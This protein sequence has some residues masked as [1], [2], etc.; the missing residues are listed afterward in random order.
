MSLIFIQL[1]WIDV[2]WG[3][4]EG[5]SYIGSYIRRE[6]DR[7]V[8]GDLNRTVRLKGINFS[9]LHW[10]SDPRKIVGG[11]HHRQRDF[12]RIR[13]MGFNVIRFNVHQ[14]LFV[15]NPQLGWRALKG[16]AWLDT[17]I[18]WARKAGIKLIIN[19]HVPLGGEKFWS[20]PDSWLD[21]L[22]ETWGELARRY[23]NEPVIAAWNLLNKPRGEVGKRW[24]FISWRLIE[25]IRKG[26]EHHLIIV[27]YPLG[28]FKPDFVVEGDD[29]LIYEFHF[30][31]PDQFTHQYVPQSGRGDGGGYDHT[32]YAYIPEERKWGG[33]IEGKP[34]KGGTTDWHW[35]E[36]QAFR[37]EDV[38]SI[39]AY[40]QLICRDE[41]GRIWLDDFRVDERFG[42]HGEW[43]TLLSVDIVSKDEL[44]QVSDKEPYPTNPYRQQVK[45][46]R[47]GSEGRSVVGEGE[48][49]HLG[50]AS[51]EVGSVQGKVALSNDRLM[52]S[53]RPGYEYRLGGW[54]RGQNVSGG[55][56]SLGV[57][58]VSLPKGMKRIPIDKGIL[59]KRLERFLRFGRDENVP[60][61][62]GEFGLSRMAFRKG[63]NG[64]RWVEDVIKLL[65]EKGLS[66]QYYDYHSRDFGLHPT[67]G[68]VDW[69]ESGVNWRL[70][71]IL[72]EGRRIRR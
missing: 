14:A 4:W 26:D 64:E 47:A 13:D 27:E 49:G 53:L 24:K 29:R 33:I 8:Y 65:D 38:R 60:L 46:W 30:Y 1:F 10:V 34:I 20:D 32:D 57:E 31:F 50:G 23:W 21:G 6:G 56:C 55:S 43:K 61:N 19:M 16:F 39:A 66:Y 5:D 35:Y 25:A 52:F 45:Y 58:K 37:S 36:G 62:V 70:E 12:E 40:P 54:M 28:S 48:L 68:T 11:R 63:R 42:F 59:R 67:E 17:N 15:D 71:S 18:R 51:L 41:P 22:A 2:V 72:K 69:P 44:W 7:L 3:S 9:N